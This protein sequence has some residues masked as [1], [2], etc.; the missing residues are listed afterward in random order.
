MHDGVPV[1]IESVPSTADSKM[2]LC[3]RAIGLLNAMR[4]APLHFAASPTEAV[5]LISAL[6]ARN[7]SPTLIVLNSFGLEEHQANLEGYFATTPMLIFQRPL[8]DG[9]KK[10]PSGVNSA[11]DPTLAERCRWN[12]GPLNAQETAQRAAQ[13]IAQY[14]RNGV[15]AIFAKQVDAPVMPKP[16]ARGIQTDSKPF[17]G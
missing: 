12:F 1:F 6:D 16:R 5:H 2:R 7:S 9:G 13:C 8:G 17:F 4:V 3:Q 15:F 11:I 10:S 14:L